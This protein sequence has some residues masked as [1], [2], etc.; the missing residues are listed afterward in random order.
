[1]RALELPGAIALGLLASLLAHTAVY[2]QSHVMGGEYHELLLVAAAIALC[3]SAVAAGAL[4]W[5]GAG[6]VISGSVLAVR[7]RLALPSVPALTVAASLW[8]TL[9]EHIEPHHSTLPLP[10]LLLAIALTSWCVSALARASLSLLATI[11]VAARPLTQHVPH[12][13]AWDERR[14]ETPHFDSALRIARRFARPPPG[15]V[16]GA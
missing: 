9:V 3:A 1:M 10:L 13:F 12:A 6:H 7:L 5:A 8:F 16:T 2:G 15:A 14:I 11:A 4:A